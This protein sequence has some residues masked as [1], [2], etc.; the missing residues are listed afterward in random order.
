MHQ[1]P[2]QG[3]ILITHRSNRALL[4]AILL[5]VG[6]HLAVVYGGWL[7]A[8]FHTSP[9]TVSELGVCLLLP[10]VVFAAVELEKLVLR[11]RSQAR[12]Q[13]AA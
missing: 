2:A 10:L 3:W 8:V 6:L 1:H 12:Q 4:G 11:R 5:T 13:V 7:G 9:L